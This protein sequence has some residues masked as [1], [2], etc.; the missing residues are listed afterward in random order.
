MLTDKEVDNSVDV[1]N[2]GQF[3]PETKSEEFVVKTVEEDEDNNNDDDDN[4]DEREK[5]EEQNNYFDGKE[6]A[7]EEEDDTNNE[8]GNDNDDDSV[9]DETIDEEDDDDEVK[10][11]KWY[12]KAKFM[13]DWVDKFAQ[14]N[15]VYPSFAIIIDEMKLFKGRSNMTHRMKKKPIKEGFKFYA[16]VCALSG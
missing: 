15:C 4:D 6:L 2:D 9:D 5:D 7:R 12:Y 3:E 16:M 10:Q 14:R 13:L 8:M 11:E 1:D